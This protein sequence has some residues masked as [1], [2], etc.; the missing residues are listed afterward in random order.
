MHVH[1]VPSLGMTRAQVAR[2]LGKSIATVR[3]LEGVLLHP[4]RD[5]RGVHRFR[6]DEVERLAIDIRRG[7]VAL[8]RKLRSTGEALVVDAP[9][10]CC[11]RCMSIE[12][13]LAALR[14]D[15]DSHRR[16]LGSLFETLQ[17]AADALDVG[18]EVEALLAEL[19]C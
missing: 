11:T 7:H 6:V 12:V 15:L 16:D 1:G 17:R 2:R 3:R 10:V 13:E 5:A 14:R 4:E 9:R 8:V 19:E 18:A